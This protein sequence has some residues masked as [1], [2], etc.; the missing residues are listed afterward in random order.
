[1]LEISGL[2]VE[3]GNPRHDEQGGI[4]AEKH[5]EDKNGAGDPG[6]ITH[7]AVGEKEWRGL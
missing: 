5:D 2:A 3:P 4:A 7:A 6:E 1:M